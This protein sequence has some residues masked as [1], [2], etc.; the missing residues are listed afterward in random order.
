MFRS[1]YIPFING[2]VIHRALENT[3]QPWA[4]VAEYAQT[5]SLHD[6]RAQQLDVPI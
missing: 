4:S 5:P 3:M 2:E 6:T 1:N